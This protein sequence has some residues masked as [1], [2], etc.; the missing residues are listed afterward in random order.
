MSEAVVWVLGG[1]AGVWAVNRMLAVW[2]V[3]RAERVRLRQDLH[4]VLHGEEH[5]TK[6]RF[7]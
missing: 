6:G 7:E 1:V 2:Y 5:K 4:R 3:R